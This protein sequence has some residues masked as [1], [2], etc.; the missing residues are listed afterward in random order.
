MSLFHKDSALEERL[1]KIKDELSLVN[2]DIRTLS[3]VVKHPDESVGL[4]R[5]KSVALR[6]ARES[7][8]SSFAA[9]AQTIEAKPVERAVVP[10]Q[11]QDRPLTQKPVLRDDKFRDY[12]SSSFDTAKPM[13]QERRVQR[14]KAITMLVAAL[15]LLFWILYSILK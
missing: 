7:V 6:K 15:A 2:K 1:K 8:K 11:V 10:V 9:P 14:N 3:D 12:L 5:L 4:P 13:R